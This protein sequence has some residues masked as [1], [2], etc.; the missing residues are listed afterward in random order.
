MPNRVTFSSIDTALD[1]VPA[2]A[3]TNRKD[4]FFLAFNP[5]GSGR[6]FFAVGNLRSDDEQKG[7]NNLSEAVTLFESMSGKAIT[8]SPEL[9]AFRAFVASVLL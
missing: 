1:Y 6:D 5:P 4:Y 8:F 2:I 9:A 7:F 3:V